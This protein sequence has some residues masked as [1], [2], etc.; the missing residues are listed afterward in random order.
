MAFQVEDTIFASICND[1]LNINNMLC[2]FRRGNDGRLH[3]RYQHL[4]SQEKWI[5]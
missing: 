4:Q 1:L 5:G 3:G 2:Q